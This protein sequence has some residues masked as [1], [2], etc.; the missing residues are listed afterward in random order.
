M[1]RKVFVVLIA[2]V[3]LLLP[4]AAYAATATYSSTLVF[5]DFDTLVP[6]P[7]AG[8]YWYVINWGDFGPTLGYY[9]DSSSVTPES[10]GG[11]TFARLSQHPDASPGNYAN[12][13]LAERYFLEDPPQDGNWAPAPGHPVVYEVRARWSDDYTTTGGTAVGTSGFWL[14]NSPVTP[15]GLIPTKSFGFMWSQPGTAYNLGGLTAVIIRGPQRPVPVFSQSISGVDMTDWNTYKV[16]W[17]SSP[18]PNETLTFYIN[19]VEVAS[20]VT[21]PLGNLSVEIWNDNQL[22]NA[23]TTT[24]QNPPSTQSIEIDYV[25]VEKQ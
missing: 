7:D 13:E 3:L 11:V 24:F 17:S 22:S 18:G 16:V 20:H 5:D 14:W 4:V 10:E 2:L 21:T 6:R 23:T 8:S 25:L 9:G 12:A 1:N 15:I 19:D